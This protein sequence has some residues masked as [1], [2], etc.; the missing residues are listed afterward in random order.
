MPD[1]EYLSLIVPIRALCEALLEDSADTQKLAS[2]TPKKSDFHNWLRVIRPLKQRYLVALGS[3]LLAVVPGM[4]L[5]LLV[6]YAISQ[7]QGQP[8]QVSWQELI[9]EHASRWITPV[10]RGGPLEAGLTVEYQRWF[11]APAL[12]LVGITANFLKGLQEFWLEEIGETISKNLRLEL[13]GKYLNSPYAV[14]KTTQGSLLASFLGDDSREIRQ[15]F[16]RLCGSIP[17][18]IF[19]SFVYLTLLLLLDTQLFVLFFSIFV[20]AG[21]IVRTTG[22]YL[23]RLAKTGVRVQTELTQSFLEKM[24]GWQSIQSFSSRKLELDRFDE[25]NSTIFN[26]WRRSARAKALSSPTVEWLG[27]TAGAFVLVLALRRVSEGALPSTILTA[28]LVTVAQLSGSLQT[29]VNQINSTK[30]G[31]AALKRLIEFL[32]NPDMAQSSAMITNF[33]SSSER[34]RIEGEFRIHAVGVGLDRPNRAGEPLL[35]N[36]EFMLQRGDNLAIVG[37]SGGGKSSLL[38]CIS[39][40]RH[41]DKGYFMFETSDGQSERNPLLASFLDVAYLTQEPFFFA[42]TIAE[43]VCYPNV[44]EPKDMSQIEKITASLD[45]ACLSNVNIFDSVLALSGGEKQRLAFARG[46]FRSPELWLIDE[47]TSAIDL[48]TE[49]QLLKNLDLHSKNAVKIFVAHRP[50]MQSYAT[51]TIVIGQ[52]SSGRT[53]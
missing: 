52:D 3:G 19:Y 36:T 9:G 32:D 17:T 16:T 43:N 23:R 12:L 24:K 26:I 46:F 5:L 49:A 38:E 28:F 2:E 31:S 25:K 8:R 11:I 48:A 13:S 4:C 37:P 27:L 40:L 35:L 7:L 6:T 42:G 51:Q 39:G 34:R 18:E 21:L 50:S 15:C 53:K 45:T 14:S 33:A 30:K 22:T 20:P 29:V 41:P 47:G 44:F 1:H 10:V